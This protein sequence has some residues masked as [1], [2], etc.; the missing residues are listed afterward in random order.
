MFRD[1]L[2]LDLDLS[3]E[4]ES[5]QGTRIRIRNPLD[6]AYCVWNQEQF[7]VKE[8]WNIYIFFS[9]NTERNPYG[10]NFWRNF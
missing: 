4:T 10:S 8:Y 3:I 1:I 7:K 5:D 6:P 2:S 9:E